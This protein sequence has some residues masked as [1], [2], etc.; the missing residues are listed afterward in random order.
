MLHPNV[1]PDRVIIDQFVLSS[2]RVRITVRV[3]SLHGYHT[4]RTFRVYRTR[5][6]TDWQHWAETS[7]LM[8]EVRAFA[9]GQ[10]VVAAFRT[11]IAEGDV[12]RVVATE[13]HQNLSR[14]FGFEWTYTNSDAQHA[15]LRAL[16]AFTGNPEHLPNGH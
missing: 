3:L 5:P 1:A 6:V 7:S 12:P 9:Q 2:G 11:A 8:G 14:K 16:Y 10:D 15:A 4:E 13:I